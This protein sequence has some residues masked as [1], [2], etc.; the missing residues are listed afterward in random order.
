MNPIT[1]PG[2]MYELYQPTLSNRLACSTIFSHGCQ[3]PTMVDHVR[4]LSTMVEC[5]QVQAV[6][7]GPVGPP[8][9]IDLAN[10][11]GSL[12]KS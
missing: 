9:E 6:P 5:V 2:G 8:Q 7:P 11:C 1:A 3:L 12:S 10:I 4:P